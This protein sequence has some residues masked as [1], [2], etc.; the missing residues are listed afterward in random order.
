MKIKRIIALL[1]LVVCIALFGACNN[2]TPTGNS[3]AGSGSSEL[4]E[5]ETLSTITVNVADNINGKASERAF[6]PVGRTFFRYSGLACDLSCTGVRFNAICKGEVKVRFRVSADCYF[7]VYINGERQEERLVTRTGDNGSFR[8]VAN[9]EEYGM[10]EIELVKQ[11]QYPMVYG[12]IVEVQLT[13]SLGKR[14]AER[15]RF[16]EFYGDS[17]MNGSNIYKGGT[18][19]A[20]SDASMAFGYVTARALGADANIIGRGGMALRHKGNTDGMLEIWDLCGGTASP[21]VAEYG[22][23][24]TPDCVVIELGTNDWRDSAYTEPLYT[25]A[26]KEMVFNIRSVYGDDVKIIWCYGYT[27][28]MRDVWGVTKATLDTI[29]D[30]GCIYY[31]EIPYCSLSKEEG[32]DG[33]HPDVKLA[34]DMATALTAFIEENIYN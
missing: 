26:V 19:A 25:A 21:E 4:V 14:P 34:Q 7:T 10:Y 32:G 27:D 6:R 3:G 29:N 13:G 17:I 11:S 22:F 28:A 24:R 8:T 15:E 1:M 33:M 9:F 31:C 20:T 16:I 23:T 30:N 2:G 5:P 18:S 12:E